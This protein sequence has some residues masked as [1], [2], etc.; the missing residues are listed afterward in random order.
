MC[1]KKAGAAQGRGEHVHTTRPS[2]PLGRFLPKQGFD[3]HRGPWPV[4]G[5]QGLAAEAPEMQ[6]PT[7]H[8]PR[9]P[10]LPHPC[11]AAPPP[12]SLLPCLLASSL[13]PPAHGSPVSGATRL[14]SRVAARSRSCSLTEPIH[15]SWLLPRENQRHCSH[16]GVDRVLNKVLKKQEGRWLSQN[17]TGRLAWA[18][19]LR[20][21][22]P[23][24]AGP[25]GKS[26]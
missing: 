5:K 16:S 19:G 8:R 18:P 20:L 6:A 24:P 14:V 26:P 9:C 3:L 4:G 23:S 10:S 1:M 21:H 15:L 11:P 2:G 12:S 13:K 25:M 17:K 22:Q 7:F